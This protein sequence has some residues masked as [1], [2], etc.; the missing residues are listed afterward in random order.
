MLSDNGFIMT[1]HPALTLLFFLI[2]L[3]RAECQ[4]NLLDSAFTFRAGTIR[5]SNALDIISRATGYNFTYDSRII[6]AEKKTKMSFT[7]IK[8][9]SI[10]DS[11]LDN[12]SLV[13]SV[14]DKYI[15]ISAKVRPVSPQ[16]D[17]LRAGKINYIT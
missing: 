7:N 6:D 3:Q 13:Y 8:L 12:D 5:T 2:L 1:K 11:L 16:A 10:L 15:I 14:I 9:S 4:V 17:S